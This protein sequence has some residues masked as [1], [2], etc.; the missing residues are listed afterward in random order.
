MAIGE[1]KL[2]AVK[3]LHA[4]GADL[5]ITDRHGRTALLLALQYGHEEIMEFLVRNGANVN[6]RL[7]AGTDLYVTF[8]QCSQRG[9][10]SSRPV[11]F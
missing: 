6:A 8:L 11:I 10:L 3:L 2:K 5:E 9:S 7:P 1:G 4:A